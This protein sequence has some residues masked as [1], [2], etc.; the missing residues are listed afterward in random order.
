M[1]LTFSSHLSDLLDLVQSCLEED[2]ELYLV[3]GG[4]RDAIMGRRLKDLD[5]VMPD[6][7]THLAKCVA[8]RLKAGF[9]ILDDDRH[10]ARVVYQPS[11]E[12]FFPLDFVQYTG[13]NLTEDLTNRD[14]TIN[15]MAIPIRKR[16]K[17]IDPLSGQPDIQAECLR[18]CQRESMLDD[19]VRILRGVRLGMELDFAYT[20]ELELLMQQAAPQLPETSYERQR[21]EFFKI[22]ESPKPAKGMRHL[23]QFQVFKTLIPPLVAQ[24]AIPASPPHVLPLFEHTLRVVEVYDH[25]LNSLTQGKTGDAPLDWWLARIVSELQP[26]SEELNL[27]FSEEITPGRT[28]RG[29]ALLGALL[30]D[31]GKPVTMTVGEDGFLHY[32]V[33]DAVGADLAWDAAKRLKLSNAES[34]FIRTLVR[35]HMRLL[36]LM[37]QDS[38]PTRQAIF[39]FYNHTDRVGVAIVI[40]SLADTIATYGKNLSKEKWRDAISV[41]KAML[42]AWWRQ[43]NTIVSPDPLLDGNDLQRLFH[44]NPGEQIGQLL[45]ALLEAQACGEV[46]TQKEAI[47]FIYDRLG[48]IEE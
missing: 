44:L 9:F 4:V 5:F 17:I 7:P 41:S 3:G 31:I 10:T 32:K 20:S 16:A 40:L 33:H 18:A 38:P 46:T 1:R 13:A 22:L 30:H 2:A 19:P 12:D 14:F 48:G 23:H 15:A 29:L 39:R 25:I 28:V 35:Y 42:F 8:D 11:D 34:E 47:A 45:A 24:E 37:N 6:D 36:P 21:D 26:F 43:R 27:Y